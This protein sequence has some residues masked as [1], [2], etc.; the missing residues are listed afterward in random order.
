MRIK[1]L[2]DYVA[3][4]QA[5][6][7]PVAQEAGGVSLSDCLA[8]A[9]CVTS[10]EAVLVD[11]QTPAALAEAVGAARAAGLEVV[12][13]VGE[14]VVAALAVLLGVSR[15]EAEGRLAAKLRAAGATRVCD[16]RLAGDAAVVAV[17]AE[18]AAHVGGAKKGPL[19]ASA[20]PGFVCYAEKAAAGGEAVLAL[21]SR[22]R[23]PQ[24]AAGVLVKERWGRTTLHATVMPCYD[25]KLEAAR[26][27]FFHDV[28]AT[29]DVDFVLAATEV[30]GFLAASGVPGMAVAAAPDA[31]ARDAP[32]AE[33]RADPRAGAS[34]GYAR[35]CFR[36]LSGGA[37]P[38]W[39][40]AGR[41]ADLVEATA[42][43][44]TKV[45]RAYGFRNIQNI[46]RRVRA[47]TSPY[48]FVEVMACPGGCGTGGGLPAPADPAEPVRQHAA[49]VASVFHGRVA[50]SMAREASDHAAAV[51]LAA[52]G[53][54]ATQ[55]HLVEEGTLAG[56]DGKRVPAPVAV[57]GS[58]W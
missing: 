49:R 27:D 25:R 45:A 17:A 2:N 16:A 53:A 46:L 15:A 41:N 29:R 4:A 26:G 9:G 58:A 36:L 33:E 55:F 40:R 47:G 14:P 30:D 19:L 48:A 38:E 56:A 23:S 13:T 54:L 10:A 42:P 7:A 44:G 34:G 37:E 11:A 6:V 28:T 35:A 52:S 20:C 39:T 21:L 31:N 1:G 18:F 5:C 8:C 12:F 24:Q 43:D 32:F 51:A 57:L 3:P 50:A 22:V